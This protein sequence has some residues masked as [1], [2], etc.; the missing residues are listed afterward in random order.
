MT[1][2]LPPALVLTAGLGRRLAP[3]TDLRAK[4]AVP[5]AGAPFILRVLRWLSAQGVPAAVLNLHHRPD[6]ITGC[7]GHG[8][9]A[10]IAVRYS[11]ERT[12]LGTAGGPRRALGMLGPRFFVVNGDTLTEVD[13]R[14]MAR[15]HAASGAL[16]TLAVTANPEPERYPGLAV[17]ERGRV[18][19]FRA[20]AR[21]AHP[22]FT[23]VQLVEAPVFAGL[24]DGEPAA[25][26]GGVYDA[27][28]AERPGAVR[29]YA[30]AATFRDIGTPRDYL[31][32]SLALA[33]AEGQP[34]LPA[35]A[36]CRM[37][38][39]AVLTRTAVWDNVV[40]EAGCRLVDCVVADGVRVPA[41]SVLE[42]QVVT[43]A[44]APPPRGGRRL[45]NAW[46]S[47]LDG[48]PAADGPGAAAGR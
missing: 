20:P 29:A 12:L 26:I 35:G 36:R 41:H 5:V 4:P 33:R 14:A 7:V 13:L 17:D 3:L 32:T 9:A 43:P 39:T 19:G 25:S 46:L 11:W 47:P 44:G 2:P 27:L 38:A 40:V 21:P 34:S 30:S 37:D 18:L 28:V 16:V 42:R 24:R 15:A 6:T 10:G 8:T 31:A 22:H 45:G 23:G 48:E 1:P